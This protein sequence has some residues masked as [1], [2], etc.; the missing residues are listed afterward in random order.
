VDKNGNTL[1]F[2]RDLES[3]WTVKNDIPHFGLK[4]HASVDTRYGFVLATEVT[5]PSHNDNPY[6]PLCV[7]GSCHTKNPL[8]PRQLNIAISVI[9]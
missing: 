7:A 1:K 2:S 8:L 5:P 4:E 3:D 6:L 9:L